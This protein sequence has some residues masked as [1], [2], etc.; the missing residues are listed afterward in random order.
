MPNTNDHFI[1]TLKRAHLEWGSHRHTSTRG[2]I[3]GEGYL[4]ISARNARNL[5]ITN[6]NSTNNNIY[7]CNSSEGF[8]VNVQL[9]S[10]GSSRAGAIHAKQFSGRRNLRLLGN[11]FTHVGARIGDRV[12]I[13][14]I[15]PT[16]ILLTKL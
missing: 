8:L 13:R 7:N 2:I 14:F 3:Y 12:E 6:S 5:N 4:Q 1:T 9:K 11:W 15:S 16:D 10:T